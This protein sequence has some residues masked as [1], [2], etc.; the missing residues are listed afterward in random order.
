MKAEIDRSKIKAI[1]ILGLLA[2]VI[3][4]ILSGSSPP[5]TFLR[6][7]Y[8]LFLLGM[9][10]CG[11]LLIRESVRARNL[12]WINIAVLGL[13]YGIIEEGLII[14]SFYNP[15]W[16]GVKLLGTAGFFLGINWIW[17]I[18]SS[19]TH[20]TLT[21]FSSIVLTESLF[22]QLADKPWLSSRQR[23]IYGLFF[24]AA[25]IFGYHLFVN[26][27]YPDYAPPILSYLLI[28][29]VTLTIAL[30]GFKFQKMTDLDKI[31]SQNHRLR[32]FILGF[33]VSLL[34]IIFPYALTKLSI[35]SLVTVFLMLG[36]IFGGS[37]IILS[38]VKR[39]GGWT[40]ADRLALA[41]GIMAPWLIRMPLLELGLMA[42][43]RQMNM[44]GMTLVAI[45]VIMILFKGFKT[46]QIREGYR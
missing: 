7:V 9:Y 8:F 25:F 36:V 44:S 22:P 3:G 39:F 23:L 5:L 42:G 41:S 20:V 30:L 31:S 2:P 14:T 46:L 45:I 40:A 17:A 19:F 38:Q 11:V 37:Y 18:F 28:A 32:Y 16:G 33:V 26:V 13:A 4:E 29:V 1:L 27:L 21:V 6:P 10:G 15:N 43:I 24:G 35:P 12:G 34:S